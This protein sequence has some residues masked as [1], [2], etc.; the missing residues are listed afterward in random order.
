M[1]ILHQY[2]HKNRKYFRDAEHLVDNLK[3]QSKFRGANVT[4]SSTKF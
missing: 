1:I 3:L 2:N 4:K